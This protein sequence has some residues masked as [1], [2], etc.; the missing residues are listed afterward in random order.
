MLIITD[1]NNIFKNLKIKSKL[2]EKK[3]SFFKKIKSNIQLNHDE[4]LVAIGIIINPSLLKKEI[5]I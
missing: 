2:K 4:I 5:R 3:L 1:E